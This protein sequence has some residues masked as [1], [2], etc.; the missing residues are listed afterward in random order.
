MLCWVAQ[1]YPTLGTPWI[2]A[3]G[4]SVH[5]ILQARILE[6]VAISF[7]R[8]SSRPGIEPTLQ[9]ESLSS[10]PPGKLPNH[11]TAREFTDH[12]LELHLETFGYYSHFV[13]VWI[14]IIHLKILLGHPS[15]LSFPLIFRFSIFVSF[16]KP[17]FF[18]MHSLYC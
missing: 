2:V 1:S 12:F 6:W 5:G 15:C 11:W 3:P 17:I 16:S 14:L 13:C 4:S 10:E 18:I 8:G 7:S 9:T